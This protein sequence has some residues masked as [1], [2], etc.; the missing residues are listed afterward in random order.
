MPDWR[1]EIR[2]RLAPLGLAPQRET[3]ITEEL[4]QHLSDRY[5]DLRARGESDAQALAR[6]REE[7]AGNALADA[8]ASTERRARASEIDPV[9]GQDTGR[10]LADL[11]RDVRYGFRSLRRTPAFTAVVV[12]TLALGIGA[13][14]AM[15]SVLNAVLLRPLPF[16]DPQN[17]VRVYAT[18][19]KAEGGIGS[20]SMADILELSSDGRAFSS[21]ATF[22][23][24]RDGFSWVAGDHAERV[25]GTVVGADFFST[26][27][28]HPIMGRV[29][30]S[31]DDAPGAPATVVLSYGFWKRRLGSDPHVLG[32]Q[33]TVQG[34]PATVLGVMPPDVWFPRSDVAELWLNDM[35]T[36]PTRR[37]PFGWGMIARI[38]SGVNP[39]QRQ[40]AL[41]QIAARVR[42][43]FPGGPTSWTFVERP[44]ADQFTRSL[45]PALVV[46]MGAVVL[47]L[48]IACVNVTNLM[49]ARATSREHEIAVR[50]ALGASRSRIVRQLLTEG[51]LLAALGGAVGLVLAVWGVRLLTASA[52]DSLTVLRDLG[53]SVDGHV[54]M[55]AAASAIGSV[56]IF[57]LAPALL[58]PARATSAIREAGRGGTDGAGRQQLRSV[59][60]AAEFAFS[61]VLLVGA[62]LLIRSLAKL[63]DVDTGV[64]AEGVVTASVALPKAGYATPAEVQSF[65]DRLL[66]EVRA[67][68]GV[69]AAS[70]SVGLP[71]DVFGSVSDFFAVSHP[72]QVGEFSPVADFLSVDGEYFATLGIPLRSGR[73]FD[74]R[75]N[76]NSPQTVMVSAE[77]ARQYLPEAD[78][79][80][81]KLSVGGRGPANEYTIVGVVGDVPYDGLARGRT[82]TM[83][84]PF[85]QFSQGQN[86]SFSV[87]IRGATPPSEMASSLRTA[88]ARI[89]PGLAVA[90]FR[91]VRDLVDASVAAD[92]FRTTLLAVFASLALLL[93]AVGI[94]GVMAYS[95]GRRARE[96]GVRI[97]LGAHAPQLYAQVL[98]EGL[99]VAGAGIAVGL[100][101]AF[102]VTRVVSKLLFGVSATDALTFC[103][104][105]LFLLAIAALA[106]LIP[107]RRAAHV[108]PSITMVAD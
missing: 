56:L 14:T 23:T 73:V 102:A 27:G 68:P 100:T 32:K 46:L 43:R 5:A 6:V 65:H 52:P 87:V 72:P 76:V 42:E 10:F 25:F 28:V 3:E 78:P 99:T 36:T 81:E 61:L 31:G 91:T 54:L 71:P 64:R 9:D 11:W 57:G 106:C 85:S 29:F 77:L 82:P 83:Y 89:D 88:V 108:D 80:G 4:T 41:D 74:A 70:I 59:L 107:A 69:A 38:R 96:I 48:L 47:V 30:Q 84:F 26:L 101:A 35:V 19:D 21:V 45:R 79:I 58:G 67:L 44:L 90:R 34:A 92:R 39:A 75:D 93:A 55:I 50:T 40:T 60:V 33:L 105:P 66:N 62:G 7:L 94:Y 20:L 1:S 97:A 98:R 13:T 17:L 104:V 63:R 49:L 15:F 51:V 53:V 24:P 18:Y 8:L 86:R 95:V 22:V 16:P 103:L 2:G 12:L 37:G